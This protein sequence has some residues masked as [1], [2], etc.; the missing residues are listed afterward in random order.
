MGLSSRLLVT[1]V[2]GMAVFSALSAADLIPN[3]IDVARLST[4]EIEDQLQV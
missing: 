2:A 1:I 4:A 3:M